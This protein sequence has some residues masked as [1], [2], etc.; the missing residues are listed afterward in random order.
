MKTMGLIH[1]SWQV[2]RGPHVSRGL[3]GLRA[4]DAGRIS[5]VAPKTFVSLVHLC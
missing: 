1:T 3:K 5:G 4:K 2:S